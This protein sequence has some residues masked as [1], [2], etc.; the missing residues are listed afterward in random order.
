MSM[1]LTSLAPAS[2]VGSAQERGA[3]IFD[4]PGTQ[5]SCRED[6]LVTVR[7]RDVLD[8]PGGAKSSEEALEAF[9]S[10]S[11]PGLASAPHERE[12]P[13]AGRALFSFPGEAG[14]RARVQVGVVGDSWHVEGFVLCS[15]VLDGGL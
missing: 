1:A 7:K 4:S 2:S 6:E 15:S 5:V 3:S 14:H 11:V 8:A 10:G 9:L 12:D 13:R